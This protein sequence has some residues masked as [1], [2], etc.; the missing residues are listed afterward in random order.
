LELVR[1]PTETPCVALLW[2]SFAA[3]LSEGS[4]SCREACGVLGVAMP[5]DFGAV[6]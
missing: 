4:L 6:L 2:A 3:H 5:G 1:R